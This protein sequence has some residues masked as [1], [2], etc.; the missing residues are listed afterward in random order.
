M[1]DKIVCKNSTIKFVLLKHL[2]YG[3]YEYHKGIQRIGRQKN[4]NMW[5]ECQPILNLEN[6]YN[7]RIQ[8]IKK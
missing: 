4:K 1:N 7:F 2:E 3:I 6:N 8:Q 5:E